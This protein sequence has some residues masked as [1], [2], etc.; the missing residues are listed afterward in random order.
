MKKHGT[1]LAIGT[2]LL[3]LSAIVG[4]AGADPT[5]IGFVNSTKLMADAPQAE[6]ARMLLKDEFAPRDQKIVKQQ[7]E[8][9]KLE[10][11]LNRDSA[12]ISDSV[13]IKKE[14]QIVS[15]KRDIKRSQEEFS[16]DLNLRRNEE[17]SKLQK[18]VYN[19]IVA[20]AKAENFDAILGDS[21]LF[22]SQ[23]IDITD[24]VLEQLQQDYKNTKQ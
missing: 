19:A 1:Q 4:I 24:K 10:E 15:L 3:L 21:V 22:A 13:R 14:R 12:V 17:L 2:F 6:A 16:E 11:E 8:L 23:R 7:K 20:V 9:K 18:T 5:K